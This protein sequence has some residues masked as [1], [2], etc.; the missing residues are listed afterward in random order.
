M[1]RRKPLSIERLTPAADCGLGTPM[2]SGQRLDVD[3]VPARQP[4]EGC[5]IAMTGRRWREVA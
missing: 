4:P 3:A 1:M 5:F 2:R